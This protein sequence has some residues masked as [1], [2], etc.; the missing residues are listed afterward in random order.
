MSTT[1]LEAKIRKNL[2]SST[3]RRERK[4][5]RV[6]GVVYGHG[7]NSIAVSVDA[8]EFNR[9]LKS[10]SGSNT[11]ITLDIEGKKDTALAR[12]I[13]RHPTRPM[14]VHVDFI[15]VNL[16]E[17]V[18]AQVP[19]HLEGEAVGVKDG[20][21]LDQSEFTITVSAKPNDIPNSIEHDVSEMEIGGVLLLS[22][23]KLPA[24]VVAIGEDDLALCSVLAPRTIT[25]EEEAADAEAAAAS[26]EQSAASAEAAGEA[27]GDTAPAKEAK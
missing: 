23:L 5:G 1:V 9:V 12:Q 15:R 6:P 16:N 10:E 11:L 27:P 14:I 19:L 24:G 4:A 13:H 17:E 3:A 7:G 22:E 26:A 20:G 8:L 25:A 2:G 18:E 21:M